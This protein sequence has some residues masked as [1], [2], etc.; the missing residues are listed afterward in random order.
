MNPFST[1]L[2]NVH[3]LLLTL[4]EKGPPANTAPTQAQNPEQ[5]DIYIYIDINR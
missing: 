5:I 3:V 2:N 4:H 1:G